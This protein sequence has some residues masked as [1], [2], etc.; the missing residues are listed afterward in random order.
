MLL[1]F[2]RCHVGV[3]LSD[4]Y[5]FMRKV[6]EKWDWNP[7][8]GLQI[9]SWYDGVLPPVRRRAGI[10]A[11][12]ALLPGEILEDHQPLL[13]QPEILDPRPDEGGSWTFSSDKRR[14]K[15]DFLRRMD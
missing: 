13:Q 15:R 11:A 4:L 2:D 10:C 3:Q 7:R 5:D 9:M 12:A 8:I 14:K 1:Q 6:M